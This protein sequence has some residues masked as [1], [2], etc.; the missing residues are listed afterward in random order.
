MNF[1]SS[2]MSKDLDLVVSKGQNWFLFDT[3]KMLR[4]IFK[5]EI[6]LTKTNVDFSLIS[7]FVPCCLLNIFWKTKKMMRESFP[8]NINRLMCKNE[9]WTAQVKVIKSRAVVEFFFRRRVVVVGG[10]PLYFLWTKHSEWWWRNG[11]FFN[12]LNSHSRLGFSVS[13]MFGFRGFHISAREECWKKNDSGKKYH[14]TITTQR[15]ASANSFPTWFAPQFF[16]T[17]SHSICYD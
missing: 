15:K 14:Y 6:I 11:F 3:K 9:H 13:W 16:C 2:K 12:S 8:W 4:R 5:R 7:P 17:D 10:D 1:L